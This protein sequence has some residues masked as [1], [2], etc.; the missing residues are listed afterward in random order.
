ML[1]LRKR[2]V[3]EARQNRLDERVDLLCRQSELGRHLQATAAFA[4]GSI[5]KR[6][7]RL[8][9]MFFRIVALARDAVYDLGGKL[10]HKREQICCV[11]AVV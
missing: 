10:Q 8:D 3:F 7:T 9:D 2:R 4:N 6:S 5:A 11:R 1:D